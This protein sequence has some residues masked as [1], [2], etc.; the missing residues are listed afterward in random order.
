MTA[1]LLFID[2]GGSPT[3]DVESIAFSL[4]A[5]R[6]PLRTQPVD[7]LEIVGYVMM[8]ADQYSRASTLLTLS[9]TSATAAGVVNGT[10]TIDISPR[11]IGVGSVA[12]SRLSAGG[13]LVDYGSTTKRATNDTELEVGE[14]GGVVV[15]R[16]TQVVDANNTDLTWSTS[17]GDVT[18]DGGGAVTI[19]VECVEFLLESCEPVPANLGPKP[20]GQFYPFTQG[21]G[22]AALDPFSS[23][24]ALAALVPISEPLSGGVPP[25]RPVLVRRMRTGLPKSRVRVVSG[26]AITSPRR[27]R[28]RPVFEVRWA[29]MPQSERDALRAFLRDDVAQGVRG[30]TIEVDGPATGRRTLRPL[31]DIT[32]QLIAV[33]VYDTVAV[34]CEEVFA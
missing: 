3:Y 18:V 31:A 8:G 32:E 29:P 5:S 33:G 12:A 28:P 27:T 24:P 15:F 11:T 23:C 17:G 34:E 10:P 19:D 13:P 9:V 20:S 16:P 22:T 14:V 26:Q 1:G 4:E 6:D 7:V 2:A 21:V 25:T 30:M